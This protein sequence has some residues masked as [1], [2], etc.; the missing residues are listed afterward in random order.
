MPPLVRIKMNTGD[1]AMAY[2]STLPE[3][4]FNQIYDALYKRTEKAT[5]DQYQAKLAKARTASQRKAC[6]GVY[7]SDWSELFNDWTRD[8]ATNLHVKECLYLGHVH[9][10][11]ALATQ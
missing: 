5:R 10:A 11:E 2:A 7:T 6:A 9:S 4:K 1:N 3:E 8:K